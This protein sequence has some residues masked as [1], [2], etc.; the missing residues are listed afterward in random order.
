MQQQLTGQGLVQQQ[1]AGLGSPGVEPGC[2][3]LPA[4]CPSHRHPSA[5]WSLISPPAAH[6]QTKVQFAPQL[7]CAAC[8][9]LPT[10]MLHL[11][12]FISE[13]AYEQDTLQI[14]LGRPLWRQQARWDGAGWTHLAVAKRNDGV[15]IAGACS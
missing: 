3:K 9:T 13:E 4:A 6:G 12:M 1:F 7:T 15:Y 5:G 10:Y 14:D 8:P 11:Q 2:I